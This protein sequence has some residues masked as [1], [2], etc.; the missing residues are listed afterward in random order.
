MMYN[1]FPSSDEIYHH[2]IKGMKWGIRRTPEQLGHKIAGKLK[3]NKKGGKVET[4]K[5][6]AKKKSDSPEETVEQKKKRVLSSRS[7]KE[8][9]DNADLFTTK[10]LQDA[11]NRL[12]LERNIKNLAP[13]EVSRGKKMVD[14]YIK[15]AKTVGEVLSAT[16][17]VLGGIKAFNKI[18]NGGK[19]DN[20]SSDNKKKKTDSKKVD[21]SSNNSSDN[22]KKKTDSKKVDSSSNNSSDNAPASKK[23][24]KREQRNSADDEPTY[25][26]PD[27]PRD[28]ARAARD[29]YEDAKSETSSEIARYNRSWYNDDNIDAGIDFA[30]NTMAA[31]MDS[32]IRGLLD[33]PD[34]RRR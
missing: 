7:A 33:D 23:T 29:V 16:N 15:G 20:D 6:S 31:L 4:A 9:Y 3:I 28:T 34:R 30:V 18:V 2:G 11:Y 24:K 19:S 12:T 1:S 5:D 26:V 21:S 25:E 22:K 8:L 32:P 17:K 27:N 13:K 10:E 14:S